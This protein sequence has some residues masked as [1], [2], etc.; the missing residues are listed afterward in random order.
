MFKY[1]Q[2]NIGEQNKIN[3]KVEKLTN[4]FPARVTNFVMYY[5]ITI[6][7]M[8]KKTEFLYKTKINLFSQ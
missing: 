1:D 7:L 5:K 3:Q 8:N 2:E 4:I 6:V